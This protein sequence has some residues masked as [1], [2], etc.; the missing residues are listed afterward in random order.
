[1]HFF[2]RAYERILTARLMESWF[3]LPFR[4]VWESEFSGRQEL[5]SSGQRWDDSG[6]SQG[7]GFAF[8]S[9][10]VLANRFA[11]NSKARE[12]LLTMAVA[13]DSEWDSAIQNNGPLEKLEQTDSMAGS[14]APK[15]HWTNPGFFEV[16][17]YLRAFRRA[18]ADVRQM[19]E[20]SRP[21]K[22]FPE[23]QQYVDLLKEAQQWRLNFGYTVSRGRF[24]K[25]ARLA[26]ETTNEDEK[27]YEAQRAAEEFIKELYPL[28]T[29]WGAPQA[30]TA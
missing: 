3:T 24:L 15:S 23:A 29:D 11:Q 13:T 28:M 21:M 12:L 4:S 5:F 9:L 1:M 10:F 26:A 18:D 2:L 16:L 25:A 22:V 6:I 19:L 17:D 27:G 8:Q 30:A 14:S 20:D 7:L